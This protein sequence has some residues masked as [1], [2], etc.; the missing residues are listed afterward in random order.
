MPA[1]TWTGQTP[2]A[3]WHEG[4]PARD[5]SAEDFDALDDGQRIVVRASRLYEEV[6]PAPK[7]GKPV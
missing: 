2:A 6:K 5:L 7:A 4:I 1:Y 3:E